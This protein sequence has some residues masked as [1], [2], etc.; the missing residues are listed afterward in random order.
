MIS[1]IIILISKLPSKD[2]MRWL[3]SIINTG[4]DTAEH[5][6]WTTHKIRLD[7]NKTKLIEIVETS[8]KQKNDVGHIVRNVWICTAPTIVTNLGKF[9][10]IWHSILLEDTECFWFECNLL[11]TILQRIISHNFFFEW[12]GYWYNWWQFLLKFPL[13]I[14]DKWI[15]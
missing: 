1:H 12:R 2:L 14:I 11:L 15:S 9:L 10:W 3:P 4:L 5:I 6:Q 7:A 8:K 13:F